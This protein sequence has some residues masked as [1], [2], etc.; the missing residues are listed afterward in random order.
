MAKAVFIIAQNEFRDE[1]FLKPKEFL[2]DRQIETLIAAPKKETAWGKLGTKVEPDLAWQD[3]S[4]EDFDVIFFVGG[5]GIK[6]YADDPVVLNLARNFDKA[7]K[8]VAAICSAPT[9]LANAG[10]L[11]GK[12]VTAFPSEEENIV[13]KGAEYTGMPVEVDGNIITGKD[14][15]SALDLASKIAWQLGE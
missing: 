7:G 10:I 8:I 5:P 9:L 14:H 13:N 6:E 4:E 15:N 11:I 12:K 2:N 3:V 1:E